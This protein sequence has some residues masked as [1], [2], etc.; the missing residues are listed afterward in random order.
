MEALVFSE[1]TYGAFEN[2]CGR[3]LLGIS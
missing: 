2:W 1:A 3:K